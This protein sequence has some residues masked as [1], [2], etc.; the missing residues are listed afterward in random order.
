MYNEA[1]RYSAKNKAY[2]DVVTVI[3]EGLH[4]HMMASRLIKYV[5]VS[6]LMLVYLQ[7]Q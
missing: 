2:R 5:S 7:I 1:Y 3:S 6:A 4:Y